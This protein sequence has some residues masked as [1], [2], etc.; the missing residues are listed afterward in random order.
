MSGLSAPALAQEKAAARA[1]ARAAGKALAG[2]R[3]AGQAISARLA[4]LAAYRAA[5]TVLAFVP[6]AGEP[7][8]TPFLEQVL[9]DGK[10]LC[11]PA[12]TG[13]GRMEARR[14]QSLAALR[15]GAFGIP[16]P[17]GPALAPGDIGLAVVPCLAAGADGTRLG[18][19]A[20]YYDRFLPGLAPGAAVAAVCRAALVA[21]SVPAGAL[22]APVDAVVCETGTIFCPAQKNG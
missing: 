18:R 2:R 10:T 1:R 5:Q 3:E 14:V 9:A 17:D 8:I 15:P 12:C 11:L 20:G 16:E 4:A 7:D 6:M 21:P 22:D 19:G 13:P